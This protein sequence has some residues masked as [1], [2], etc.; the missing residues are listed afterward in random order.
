MHFVKMENHKK[1]SIILPVNFTL[2]LIKT[3][4]VKFQNRSL[5]KLLNLSLRGKSFQAIEEK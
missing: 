3:V 5:W 2:K 4:M 1:K